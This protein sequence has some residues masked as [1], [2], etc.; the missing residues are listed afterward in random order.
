MIGVRNVGYD[1]NLEK[2]IDAPFIHWDNNPV[3]ITALEAMEAAAGGTRG[4]A[5]NEA[6]E[7]LNSRL[8]MGPVPVDNLLAEAKANCIAEKTLRRAK[9][10]LKIVSEKKHGST[11]G[12]WCWRLPSSTTKDGHQHS[13]DAMRRMVG[14][15]A[16]LAMFEDGH[17]KAKSLIYYKGGQHGHFPTLWP[18]SPVAVRFSAGGGP[19]GARRPPKFQ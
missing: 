6:V 13:E 4:N 12:E 18:S 17:R 10:E 8:I 7:F 5:L 11:T 2:Q 9:R 16:M 19:D 3:K 14:M 1:Q 15:L